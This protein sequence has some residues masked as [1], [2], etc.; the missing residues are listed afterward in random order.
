MTKNNHDLL[1]KNRHLYDE[2]WGG[3]WLLE[4]DQYNTWPLIESLLKEHTSRLEVAPGLRPRLPTRGTTF[5]DVSQA[6]LDALKKHG[7]KT[8]CASISHLPFPDQTFDL[9]CALDIIEHVED[10]ES[11]LTELARVASDG[12]RLIL[13]TPLHPDLWTPFD[14]FV[15]HYRRYEPS[16]ILA[17]LEKNGF[18]VSQSAIFGMKPKS[19]FIVNLGMWFLKHHPKRAM[20][21]YNRV[22]PH[23]ARRQAPL[24]LKD[25]LITMDDIGE[26]FVICEYRKSI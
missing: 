12:A 14:E 3:G 1:E 5:V 18:L 7:G 25:G 9:I 21:W 6:A 4:A 16:R 8:A 20:W 13:S 17:L 24:E 15:G 10:D 22:F 2:I 23:I 11:A 19:S 26:I